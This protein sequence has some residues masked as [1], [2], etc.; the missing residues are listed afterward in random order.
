MAESETP[1]AELPKNSVADN[2]LVNKILNQ[3]DG[4]S[5]T[6]QPQ[7]VETEMPSRQQPV[8]NNV[9]A[10]HIP[11][12]P[13]NY[14]PEEIYHP[15]PQRTVERKV[16]FKDDM[17]TPSSV[18]K[19]LSMFNTP[20]FYAKVKFS[21][22]CAL[23]FF[24]FIVFSDNFKNL[25]SKLPLQTVTATGV[26]NNTGIFLQATCFGIIH[27]GLSIFFDK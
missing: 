16:R 9:P 27:L 15:S 22:M 20:Q 26:F 6:D 25:F 1:L 11:S 4:S 5:A 2:D 23:I 3:L 12:M 10:H 18:Q 8:E 24:L 13:P 14:Q 21:V 19:T 7:V 17:P